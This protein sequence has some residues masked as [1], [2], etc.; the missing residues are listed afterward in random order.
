MDLCTLLY[1]TTSSGV[2]VNE[3]KN[4]IKK[5]FPTLPIQGINNH[6]FIIFQIKAWKTLNKNKTK[7]HTIR[8][9]EF[10]K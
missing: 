9:K 2:D 7:N 1:P 3:K 6:P 5:E 8:I 4:S 10:K